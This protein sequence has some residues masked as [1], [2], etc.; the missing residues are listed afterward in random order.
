[1]KPPAS[2][3]EAPPN[4]CG[5]SVDKGGSSV[6]TLENVVDPMTTGNVELVVDELLVL[7]LCDIVMF[8]LDMVMLL[9]ALTLAPSMSPAS[10]L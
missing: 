1:M 9:V 7:L 2:N 6:N 4:F 10:E 8:A 3:T 5:D